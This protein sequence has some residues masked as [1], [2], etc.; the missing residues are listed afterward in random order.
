MYVRELHARYRLRR[1]HGWSLPLGPVQTP[2]EAARLFVTILREEVVEVGGLLCLS[3]RHEVLAYH[4]LSR[5]TVDGTIMHPR[6][7]FKAALL[8]NAS[9]VILGHNHPSGNVTP[10]PED[11]AITTRIASGG[12]LMGIQLADHVIV[13]ADGTYFSFKESG[14]LSITPSSQGGL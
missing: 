10:S 13:S 11:L 3:T 1:L 7:V 5:G 4:E 8:A 2:K 14:S 9:A 6:E 12:E